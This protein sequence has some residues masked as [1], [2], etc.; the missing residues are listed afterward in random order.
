MASLSKQD[1]RYYLKF[2]D[3]A[4]RPRRKTL[5]LKVRTKDAASRLQLK[6]ENDYA[7]GRFDPWT[8]DPFTYD[9]TPVRTQVSTLRAAYDAFMLTRAGC[10][11]TTRDHYRWCLEPFVTF[12]GDDFPTK[13][14]TWQLV[15]AWLDST[16][17]G[18]QSRHTYLSRIGIFC[19][20]LVEE[21]V[22]KADVSK[23]VPLEDPPDKFAQKLITES[24]LDRIVALAQRSRVPYV[25]DLAVVAFSL[26]LRLG[27]VCAMKRSW[28]NLEA[29]RLTIVQSDGFATKSGR[30]ASKPIPERALAVLAKRCDRL[31]ADDYVFRNTKGRPLEPKQTSKMFKKLVRRAK[32]PEA[33]T[34][35]GLRHGGISKAVAGGASIEAVRRFASHAKTDMTM[36]YVHLLDDQYADQVLRAMD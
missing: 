35:H 1:G 14:L 32:L 33:Y 22:L 30:E 18:V 28:V 5:S 11:T 36:R 9:R 31:G 29:R 16:G 10:R 27:E 7:L 8:D 13:Q 26:A 6:L 4:R 15:L 17:A 25:A 12:L 24:D 19:R 2:Y 20:F 23:K 3:E 34:F 21:G